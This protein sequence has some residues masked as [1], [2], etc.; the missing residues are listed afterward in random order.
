MLP[1]SLQVTRY[2]IVVAARVE[3]SAGVQDAYNALYITS[4]DMWQR[5]PS[6]EQQQARAAQYLFITI[7]NFAF[8]ARYGTL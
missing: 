1:F 6:H 4:N 5:M 8:K 2:L 7:R 3:C